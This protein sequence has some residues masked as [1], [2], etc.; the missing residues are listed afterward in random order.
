M[1]KNL[2]FDFDGTISDSYPIFVRIVRQVAKDFDVEVTM[3]DE[4]LL[5]KLVVNVKH[6]MDNMN[7]RCEL[8][9]RGQAFWGYQR[10]YY[11][12]FQA[13]PEIKPIL[14]KSL[15]LGK[16]NYIYT[17]SG[18]IVL[19]MLKNMGLDGYFTGV[20]TADHGF[21]SK[22]APDAL[23]YLCKTYGLDPSESLMIGDRDIDTM[24]G[25]NAG[26]KG[27][28]WDPCDRYAEYQTDYKIKKLSEL[29]DLLDHI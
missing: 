8:H 10:Q 2:I 20:V 16:K 6:C 28:L 17:H 25:N 26:T 5:D 9:E 12:E 7:F 18:D 29:Y 13:F 4:E 1:I 11:K 21:P 22:P 14:E 15:A 27:C 19:K 3:S 23:F 24:A